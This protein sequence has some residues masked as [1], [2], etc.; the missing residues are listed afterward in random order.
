MRIRLNTRVVTFFWVGLLVIRSGIAADYSLRF[1]GNGVSAPGLDRV[2]VL[3]NDPHRPV[4]V[5]AGDFTVEWWMKANLAE[6]TSG[7]CSEGK[8]NWI[9]GNILLDRDIWGAGDWGDW[10]VSVRGG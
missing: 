3:L 5:G 9:F 2:T 10:G 8:D 6:N 1:Y 7:S 4:D